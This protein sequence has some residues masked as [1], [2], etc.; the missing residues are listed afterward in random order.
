MTIFR[1]FFFLIPNENEL[2]FSNIDYLSPENVFQIVYKCFLPNPHN[3]RIWIFNKILNAK[4]FQHLTFWF[5]TSSHTHTQ[6]F[7]RVLISFV[8][9]KLSL[10]S[11]SCWKN[12]ATGIQYPTTIVRLI[13]PMYVSASWARNIYM[14]VFCLKHV[15]ITQSKRISIFLSNSSEVISKLMWIKTK[16]NGRR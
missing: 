7:H 15:F 5:R 6:I 13:Y 4:R 14:L 8:K 10:I 11:C 1:I 16:L 3:W 9:L 2:H 12:F